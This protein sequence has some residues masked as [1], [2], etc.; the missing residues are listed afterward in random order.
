MPFFGQEEAAY[1]RADDLVPG[2]NLLE[3]GVGHGEPAGDGAP[4]IRAQL[5]DVWVDAAVVFAEVDVG[6]K[7]GAVGLVD[8]PGLDDELG[9]WVGVG[10]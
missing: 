10:V 8:L 9:N 6:L 5:V 4:V 2:G 7:E 3:V 1:H